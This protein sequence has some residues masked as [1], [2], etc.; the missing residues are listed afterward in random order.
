MRL[1]QQMRAMGIEDPGLL[2]RAAA[3]DN[4]TAELLHQSRTQL[5][6]DE[7][8]GPGNGDHQRR[9]PA[10]LAAADDPNDPAAALKPAAASRQQASPRSSR[11]HS[12]GSTRRRG[13]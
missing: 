5:P 1:Y 12:S 3:I 8:N 6:A 2:L 10:Q 7:A 9:M 13:A 11:S 4:A